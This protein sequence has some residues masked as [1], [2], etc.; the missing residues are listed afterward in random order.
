MSGGAGRFKW[1]VWAAALAA[2]AVALLGLAGWSGARSQRS[3]AYCTQSCHVGS[4]EHG[5][6]SA[7]HEKVACQACHAITPGAGIRLSASRL[8][9]GKGSAKHGLV[10]AASCAACHGQKSS[11]WVRIS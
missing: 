7:G 9:G 4:A 10:K 8:V 11:E 5:Y 6:A 3:A 2:V 1:R